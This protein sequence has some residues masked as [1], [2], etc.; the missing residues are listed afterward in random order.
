MHTCIYTAESLYCPPEIIITCLISYTPIEKEKLKKY[1]HLRKI[2]GKNINNNMKA[3][4]EFNA[5]YGTV[6]I[7]HDTHLKALLLAWL[8]TNLQLM[9]PLLVINYIV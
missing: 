7:I 9:R 8:I 5:G 4:G 1:C 2:S 6:M 3:Y